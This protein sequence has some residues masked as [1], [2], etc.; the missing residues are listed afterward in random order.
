MESKKGRR[1]RRH[2]H[3][4]GVREIKRQKTETFREKIPLE[5]G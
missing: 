1:N 4:D 2:T 3:R 5:Y